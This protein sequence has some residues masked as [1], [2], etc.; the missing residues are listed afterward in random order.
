MSWIYIFIAGTFE[1]TWAVAL[2]FTEGFT[3]FIPSAVFVVALVLSSYFLAMG[4]KSIPIGTAYGVWTGI[5]VVGTT[6][7]G[8]FLFN[9]PHNLARIVFL[10]L[11]IIG[12]VGLKLTTH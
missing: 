3:R 4:I 12:I 2:K 11:L 8:I 1:V 10:T 5:G 9:E 7:L 6:I